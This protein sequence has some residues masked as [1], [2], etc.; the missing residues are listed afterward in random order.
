MRN[1]EVMYILKPELEEEAINAAVTRFED[2]VQTNGG[3]IVK[4]DRWG[5]RRLAHEVKGYFEGFYV[6]MYIKAPSNAGQEI[7]RVLKIHDGV[8]RH[9]VIKTDE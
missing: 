3:E 9:L 4:T 6:L 7:D 2:V 8:I 1:Y 5:K